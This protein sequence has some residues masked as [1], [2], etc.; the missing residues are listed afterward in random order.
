MT[1]L[2]RASDY[3]GYTTDLCE[4]AQLV[5]LKCAGPWNRRVFLAGGLV[6]RYLIPTLPVYAAPH[7]G[8]TDIDLV[9]GIAIAS[10]DA[11]PYDTLL[12][13]IKAAGFR[14]FEGEDGA[15][16]SF[17]W[18]IDIDGKAVI[19]EFL[20][21][22]GED[23]GSIVRPRN[24]TGAK[25]GAFE[26]RGAS[27]VAR[28]YVE[29]EIRGELPGGDESFATIRVANLVPFVVLKS[30][31]LHDRALTKLKDAYDIVFVLQNWPGGPEAAALAAKGSPVFAEPIV[32]EALGLLGGHFEHVNMD[33]PG[34]YA[35]FLLEEEDE[36]E[37]A[38]LRNE[39]VA[40]VRTFVA[41][42]E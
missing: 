37:D 40:V 34:N 39:A 22:Q 21:E 10:D 27:L 36:E 32:E 15:T 5:L 28:D 23:P 18:C 3:D 13:N 7:V 14:L 6:P 35:R 24:R 26:T 12:A 4:R 2:M 29:R 38:R 31:A 17:R 8:T 1:E 41:G 33:G 11:E 25:L 19:V 30:F 42:L 9:I 16:V 20:T